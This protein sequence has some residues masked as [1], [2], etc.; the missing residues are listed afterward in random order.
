MKIDGII[1]GFEDLDVNI[2]LARWG[3][4][5]R[6]EFIH[7]V[8]IVLGKWSGKGEKY[9][10]ETQE[11]KEFFLEGWVECLECFSAKVLIK[12]L[13]YILDGKYDKNYAKIPRSPLDFKD[14]IMKPSFHVEEEKPL[15]LEHYEGDKLFSSLSKE[16]RS[17]HFKELMKIIRINSQKKK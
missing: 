1:K 8:L 9:F 16:E 17:R 3:V 5:D 7:R 14:F 13:R 10:W 6:K 4:F 11:E 15:M 2:A 12:N